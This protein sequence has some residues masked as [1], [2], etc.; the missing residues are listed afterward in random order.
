MKKFLGYC[1]IF[2]GGAIVG[3]ITDKKYG[4][5]KKAGDY[6]SDKLPK[7]PEPGGNTTTTTENDSASSNEAKAS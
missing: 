6:I 3:A 5:T 7:Q 1:M 4:W 2:L